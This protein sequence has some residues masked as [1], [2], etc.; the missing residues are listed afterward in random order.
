MYLEQIKN[1]IG[2]V[3]IFKLGII[4]LQLLS[5]FI[6]IISKNYS[7]NYIIQYFITFHFFYLIIF[8]KLK[9]VKNLMIVK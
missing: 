2:Y 9:N 7:K 5:E 8:E 3:I 4:I 1:K 6:I